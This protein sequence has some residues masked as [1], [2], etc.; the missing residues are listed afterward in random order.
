VT[1]EERRKKNTLALLPR[2]RKRRSFK[3][4]KKEVK[5]HLEM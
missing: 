1:K 2:E 4:F 5:L 3:D